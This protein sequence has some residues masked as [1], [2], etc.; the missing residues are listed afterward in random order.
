MDYSCP[1]CSRV[2][3][4]AEAIS[5][6]PFCGTAYAS[7]PGASAVSTTRIVIGS[8]SER[9]V[10][11]KYWNL[12]HAEISLVLSA[13][14]GRLPSH[15]EYTL[16]QLNVRGWLISQSKRSSTAQF[17]GGCDA[18]LAEITQAF[19]SGPSAEP[20]VPPIDIDQMGKAMDD[21]CQQLLNV[22]RPEGDLP[23]L[24]QLA[25][26]PINTAAKPDDALSAACMTLLQTIEAIKPR[27]YQVLNENGIFTAA[28][29]VSR[30]AGDAR[31][32]DVHS[33]EKLSQELQSLAQQDYDPLFGAGF[34]DFLVTF[35]MSLAALATAA[36]TLHGWLKYDEN[37][38]A[39]I[40]A[41]SSC[42]AAWSILLYETLDQ[43]Y[44]SQ[45]ADMLSIQ[46]SVRQ[47]CLDYAKAAPD[48]A[49]E[50]EYE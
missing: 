35:M 16:R 32:T 30:S 24:P 49:D 31:G 48:I 20:A 3:S 42:R 47:I 28:S 41:L 23:P 25:F 50:D 36:N 44:Q 5:F 26:Q 9:A 34:E 11:E 33:L 39:K 18:F 22:I 38:L 46:R 8:D 6:C 29:I 14:E 43:L 10:Q 1:K 15:E 21:I 13:L 17:R 2:F 40:N 12:T 45:R 4:C 27:F 37:E 7:A 19:Q